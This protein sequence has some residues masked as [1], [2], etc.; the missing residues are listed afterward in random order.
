MTRPQRFGSLWVL[1]S[2]LVVSATCTAGPPMSAPGGESLGTVSIALMSGAGI[3]FSSVQYALVEPSGATE[4]SGQVDVSQS[5]AIATV[6]AGVRPEQNLTVRLDAQSTD[7]RTKCSGTS[8]PFPVTADHTTSVTVR[9]SCPA[10]AQSGT[11]AVNGTV[12]LC[13]SLDS[14][15]ANPSEAN[16]GASISLVASASDPDN[17]PSSLTYAWSATGSAGVVTASSLA[18]TS[19][20][21][22]KSGPATVTLTVSDGDAKC[23][24]TT[25]FS[26]M[27]DAT[28]VTLYP[29]VHVADAT[30]NGLLASYDP[31]SGLLVFSAMTAVLSKLTAGDVLLS[32]GAAGA[33]APH[34]YMRKIVSVQPNGAGVQLSTT[35]AT[36]QDVVSSANIDSNQKPAGLDT[37]TSFTPAKTG[38]SLAVPAGSAG[39]VS[40][41]LVAPSA[42]VAL[43][44]PLP[45]P[46]GSP[47]GPAPSGGI[48]I[49]LDH[50]VIQYPTDDQ[51]MSGSK[52]DPGGGL[53]GQIQATLNGWINITPTAFVHMDVEGCG[54]PFCRYVHEFDAGVVLDQSADV[55]ADIQASASYETPPQ[56][57]AEFDAGSF[58]T[59]V[60][61]WFPKFEVFSKVGVSGQITISVHATDEVHLRLG[62]RWDDDHLGHSE[63]SN[64]GSAAATGTF[65]VPSVAASLTAKASAVAQADL[66]LYDTVGSTAATEA[67]LVFD[68]ATPRRPFA[69]VGL[70]L[71]QSFGVEISV[72][73]FWQI[74]YGAQLPELDFPIGQSPNIPPIIVQ[75]SP[76][77]GSN[78]AADQLQL[79]VVAYDLQDG[80]NLTYRWSDEAGHVLGTQSDVSL[81][82]GF[83][84]GL[85]TFSVDVTDAAG[86]TTTAAVSNVTVTAPPP[87]VVAIVTPTADE[88]ETVGLPF[89]LSGSA[90]DDAGVARCSDP[91]WSFVWTD[92]T[93]GA[94]LASG[95]NANTTLVSAGAH[96]LA[97]TASG[98]SG[99]ATAAVSVTASSTS[100]LNA[101]IATGLPTQ[102]NGSVSNYFLATSEECL[103]SSPLPLIGVAAGGTPP[104]SYQWTAQ[105]EPATGTAPAPVTVANTASAETSQ[106]PANWPSLLSPV[107]SQSAGEAVVLTFEVM[108]ASGAIARKAQQ[109]VWACAPP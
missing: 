10:Q 40:A 76:P 50:V 22:A 27:C 59:Y 68:I 55:Q 31:K 88:Q 9:L 94:V 107:E 109:V 16:V 34:G 80:T 106:F 19:F 103:P 69:N 32:G 71:T 101:S 7:G 6:I 3:A 61:C 93:T 4:R 92:R 77:S 83:A 29:N 8:S 12:N 43:P 45:I 14:A 78:W 33:A 86:T 63:W 60:L 46:P 17:G 52:N 11:V 67:A 70:A 91:A 2:A 24:A 36:L 82:G 35:P 90:V 98:P 53:S 105:P 102:Q 100:E 79:K 81:P 72:F 23:D 97:L 25:T 54:D 26:I 21:C 41:A 99:S 65:D 62:A 37:V 66:L 73:G 89:A 56:K 47:V 51:F 75:T 5:R 96:I 44:S 104:Y 95:C 48:T 87:P 108:D 28:G 64:L 49:N 74:G 42:F 38:V 57:L 13:P 30:T 1:L 58:C 84:P 85:H 39:L 18:S 15:L 20:V